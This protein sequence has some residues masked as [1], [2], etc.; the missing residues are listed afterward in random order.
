MVLDVCYSKYENRHCVGGLLRIMHN[1]VLSS[2]LAECSSD[3][4][5]GSV[6]LYQCNEQHDQLYLCSKGSVVYVS[7]P[8]LTERSSCLFSK[9]YSYGSYS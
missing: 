6:Y 8:S 3:E 2:A 9:E 4:S 1:G 7:N 5:C